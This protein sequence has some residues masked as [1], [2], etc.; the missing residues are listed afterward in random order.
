LM[1]QSS[2]FYLGHFSRFI[3]PGAQRL[4]CAAS[5]QDLEVTAFVNLDGSQV[6][7][8]LNRSEAA[9]RYKLKWDARQ[10]SAEAPARSICSWV[11]S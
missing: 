7:V 8:V 2:Y 3:K 5:R 4:L 1:P 6:L 11:A 10:G 9:I